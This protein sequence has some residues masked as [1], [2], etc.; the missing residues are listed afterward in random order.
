MDY[1]SPAFQDFVRQAREFLQVDADRS[2][3]QE[4]W[5]GADADVNRAI[6]HIMDTPPE[7]VR[8]SGQG[9]FSQPS[10][11]SKDTKKKKSSKSKNYHGSDVEGYGD[12]KA[13]RKAKR[14]AKRAA[15]Q[16]QQQQ[17][18][19]QAFSQGFPAPPPN[20][21]NGAPPVNPMAGAQNGPAG[22]FGVINNPPAGN[23]SNGVTGPRPSTSPSPGREGPQ[24]SAMT[25]MQQAV[26]G[27]IQ[28]L[29]SQLI[30]LMQHTINATPTSNVVAAQQHNLLSS[31]Q[32]QVNSISNSL[33]ASTKLPY[34]QQQNS[35]DTINKQIQAVQLDRKSKCKLKF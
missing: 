30:V 13:V 21:A 4:V 17:Q 22:M 11:P 1:D 12:E 25:A 18:Q 9:V 7:K 2:W 20:F 8:K 33:T 15:A 26:G 34:P 3:L 23:Y 14:A 16:Q 5:L 10:S 6:N 31:M 24:P 27:A 28:A 19:Q 29:Q 35:L 32:T